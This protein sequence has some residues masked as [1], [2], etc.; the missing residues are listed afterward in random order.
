[1]S[2]TD[3]DKLLAFVNGLVHDKMSGR[4]SNVF[5][6]FERKVTR[7]EERNYLAHQM[8]AIRKGHT[9]SVI[10]E[11]NDR[12]VG[13]GNV[14][15]GNYSETQ[16]HAHLGLTVLAEYRGKGI[17]REMVKVLLREAKK[18]GVRSVEVEF[19][20]TNQAAIHT[21]RNVGFK[22]AGRITRKVHRNGKYLDSLIMVR[23]L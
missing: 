17:G 9:I 15:K 14:D 21:Y 8:G 1:M 16:H 3:L 13:N 11:V 5:T 12:I 18:G 6:G 23:Q 20:A 22:Q 4:G 7:R 19:L 10:A 2:W